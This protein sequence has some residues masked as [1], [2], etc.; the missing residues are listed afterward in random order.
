MTAFSVKAKEKTQGGFGD[1]AAAASFKDVMGNLA[2]FSSKLPSITPAN[3]PAP[4]G[5]LDADNVTTAGMG[6]MSNLNRSISN[7]SQIRVLEKQM[8]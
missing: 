7:K 1:A 5:T 4:K 6:L 3:K 8:Y 2:A